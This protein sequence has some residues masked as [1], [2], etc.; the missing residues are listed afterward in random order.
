MAEKPKREGS[1]GGEG[2]RN[3]SPGGERYLGSFKRGGKVKKTGNYR[4]HEGE[5]VV[6]KGGRKN[7][8]KKRKSRRRQGRGGR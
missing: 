6:P 3:M 1:G 4:L 7:K 8:R 2:F 5:T